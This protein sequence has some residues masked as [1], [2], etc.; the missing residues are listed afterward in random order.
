MNAE[1]KQTVEKEKYALTGYIKD[2]PEQALI[3]VKNECAG[4]KTLISK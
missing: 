4:N 1:V 2:G 3:Q